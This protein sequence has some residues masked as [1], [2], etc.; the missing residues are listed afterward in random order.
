LVRPGRG[1]I[2]LIMILLLAILAGSVVYIVRRNDHN[3]PLEIFLPAP[4]VHNIEVYVD[5]GVNDPGVYNLPG[6]T[7]LSQ[8]P[9][10]FGGLKEEADYDRIEIKIVESD[11]ATPEA[12]QK[13]NLNTAPDWLLEALPG[14]GPIIAKNIIDYRSQHPF[15]RINQ[16]MQVEGVGP[17]IFK[18]V[19]DLITVE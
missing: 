17:A 18:G 4:S 1:W 10:A 12:P 5:D 7:K 11:Q 2:I 15:E 3:P 19:K 6:D 8:L 14:I 13:I 16:L 9:Q